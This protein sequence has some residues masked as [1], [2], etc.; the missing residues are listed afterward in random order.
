VAETEE[1]EDQVNAEYI[2]E[3]AEEDEDRT[4]LSERRVNEMLEKFKKK[5]KTLKRRFRRSPE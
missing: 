4:P 3:N 1:P 5:G 2:E